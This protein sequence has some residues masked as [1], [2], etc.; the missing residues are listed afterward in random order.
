MN[1]TLTRNPTALKQLAA[2]GARLRPFPADVMNAA[3]KESIKLY[4]ELSDTNPV[5]VKVCAVYAKF[6]GDQKSVV[7]LY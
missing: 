3:F 1:C 5:W 7:S 4:A 2:A 6:R